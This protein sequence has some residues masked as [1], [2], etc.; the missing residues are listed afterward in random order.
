MRYFVTQFEPGQCVEFQFT[1]PVGF[2][3]CHLFK[4]IS[5]NENSTLLRHELSMSPSGRAIL[6]WPLFFRPLHNALIEESLDRA[7]IE[8]GS[9]PILAHRRSFWT[10]LLRAPLTARRSGKRN[11][12]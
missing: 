9:S 7:E 11:D 8:L 4:V 6:T 1:N 3:G 10:R 2:N 5:L 12:R